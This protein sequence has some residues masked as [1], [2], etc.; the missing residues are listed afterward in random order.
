MLKLKELNLSNMF[1]PKILYLDEIFFFFKVCDLQCTFFLENILYKR[2]LSVRIR[3][4]KDA[5]LVAASGAS[6]YQGRT[7]GEVRAARGIWLNSYCHSAERRG[8][9]SFACL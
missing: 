7:L 6:L 9:G 2:I 8:K 4:G 1:S 5:I 3:S